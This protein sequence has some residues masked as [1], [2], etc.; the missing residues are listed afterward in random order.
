MAPSDWLQA[1]GKLVLV[2]D[3]DAVRRSITLMLRAHGFSIEA[4]HSGAELLCN[5]ILPDADCFLIDYKMP[6]VDGLDLLG[7]L[8]SAGLLAPALMITGYV[9]TTLEARARAAGYS[10]IIEKPPPERLLVEYIQSLLNS[11]G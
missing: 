6:G 2:E 8:R 1:R 9:S 11:T 3:D 7:R 4:Y 5:R 10:D